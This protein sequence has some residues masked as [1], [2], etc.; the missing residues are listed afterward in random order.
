MRRTIRA[1]ICAT[2]R[3]VW[4]ARA[5]LT[6]SILLVGVALVGAVVE[7]LEAIST[8]PPAVRGLRLGLALD[9]V[10]SQLGGEGWTTQLDTWG[11]LVLARPGERYDFHE[12]QLVR[13]EVTL[14]ASDADAAGADRV[15]TPL[16]VLSRERTS[17]GRVT[18]R[19]ISR[20][21]PTHREEAE[22]LAASA[23]R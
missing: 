3:R 21:C 1:R 17:D 8:P 16:T 14:E 15:V 9:E 13:V 4:L 2:P 19:M 6:G 18:V 20:L 10:R 23:A 12:G 7:R 11:D 22:A 5:S